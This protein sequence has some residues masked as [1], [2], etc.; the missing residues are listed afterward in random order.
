MLNVI[1]GLTMCVMLLVGRFW[2]IF[3]SFR[4]QSSSCHC[5]KMEYPVINQG[6]SK[7]VVSLY[8]EYQFEPFQLFLVSSQYKVGEKHVVFTKEQVPS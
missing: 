6:I 1:F 8:S 7:I 2:D 4:S 5:Y 3:L